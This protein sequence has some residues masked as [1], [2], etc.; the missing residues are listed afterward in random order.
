MAVAG[1]KR[2][3][4]TRPLQKTTPCPCSN[5]CKRWAGPPL[6]FCLT[7]SN[8]KVATSFHQ[9]TI[10]GQ[11]EMRTS[12]FVI[13]MLLL[14]KIDSTTLT[15]FRARCKGFVQRFYAQSMEDGSRRCF[16]IGRDWMW[17]HQLFSMICRHIYIYIIILILIYIYIHVRACD[18]VCVM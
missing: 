6:A 11:S 10:H 14:V 12:C 3:Y 13:N 16:L 7:F 8:R 15:A 4:C 2:L 9:G 18:C 5:G 1:W 17:A